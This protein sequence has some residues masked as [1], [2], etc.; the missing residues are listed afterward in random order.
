V[1]VEAEPPHAVEDAL[2][3]GPRRAWHGALGA[4]L[5]ATAADIVDGLDATADAVESAL[6]EALRKAT[7]ARHWSIVGQL[8][9]ELEARRQARAERPQRELRAGDGPRVNL[10][11]ARPASDGAALLAQLKRNPPELMGEIPE[12]LTSKILD[13]LAARVNRTPGGRR[14]GWTPAKAVELAELWAAEPD[15]FAAVQR[16]VKKRVESRTKRRGKRSKRRMQ[17]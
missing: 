15:V 10:M 7:E 13:Y 9:R 3:E 8:A 12:G 16:E 2:G 6:A 5:T 1:A 11:P 4:A 17:K 14:G